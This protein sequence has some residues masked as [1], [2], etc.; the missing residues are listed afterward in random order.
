MAGGGAALHEA[1]GSF[2]LVGG[3]RRAGG[4]DEQQAEALARL[5]FSGNQRPVEADRLRLR[6][7]RPKAGEQSRKQDQGRRAADGAGA[8][9]LPEFRLC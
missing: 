9:Q 1:V 5:D 3:S 6:R 8:A 4:G 7:P 2:D